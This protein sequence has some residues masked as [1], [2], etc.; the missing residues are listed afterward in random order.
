M[1]RSFLR[2]LRL[3]L[4][5]TLLVLAFF[6]GP[7]VPDASAAC[8][9]YGYIDEFYTDSTYSVPCGTYNSCTRTYSGC[10]TTYRLTETTICYCRTPY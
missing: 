7:A 8:W 4:P 6:A 1:N 10:R 5:V 3:A 2:Y 9:F